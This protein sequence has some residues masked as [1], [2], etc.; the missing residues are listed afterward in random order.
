MSGKNPGL[1]LAFGSAIC[2]TFLNIGAR[3]ALDDLHLTAWGL[4]FLRGIV[5]LA[6]TWALARH[7][8]ISVFGR[9]PKTLALIGFCSFTATVLV[10]VAIGL[11]P[12]YQVLV[13]LYLYPALT[14][15][16]SYFINGDRVSRRDL[17][18]I[19][20]AFTGCLILLWP[21]QTSG[22]D[23]NWGH[24]IGA[25]SPVF[26]ALAYV[27]ANRLGEG[28]NGLEPIFYYGCWALIGN[29]VII[30]FLGGETGI[31]GV[32][33]LL[34]GL[35]LAVLAVTALL[36]GYAALRWVKAFKVGVIGNLEVFGA[37][38]ASWLVFNDPITLRA[39]LGGVIILTAA[40]KLRQGGE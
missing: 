10:T 1:P 32:G 12:L 20:L 21:D 19:A 23:L 29:L 35:G 30:L 8:K 31:T 6:V 38:V 24:L 33:T 40:L 2:Y 3:Y 37:V 14:V 26:Y 36:T 39:L 13:L 16:L 4:L 22:L 25:A 18:L 11:I 7:L 34:P 17:G 9:Q 5:A 15:P 27:L 28:N